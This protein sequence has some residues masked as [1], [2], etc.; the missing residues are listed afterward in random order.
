M[1]RT[2][3]I[4]EQSFN[5]LH[6]QT[7]ISEYEF[8]LAVRTFIKSVL[9]NPINY[10]FPTILADKGI[11]AKEL[12]SELEKHKI[13]TKVE[14]LDDSSGKPKLKVKYDLDPTKLELVIAKLYTKYFDDTIE[15]CDA[16][17]ATS[18]GCIS[19][20]VGPLNVIRRAN[21]NMIKPFLK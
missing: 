4:S 13:L 21:S 8:T 5:S 19:G 14:T 7:T 17:G 9:K 16:A 6:K 20:F 12:I 11:D 2:I 10:T 15:E 18:A 3:L 1:P